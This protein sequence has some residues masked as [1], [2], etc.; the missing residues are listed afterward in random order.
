RDGTWSGTS[1]SPPRPPVSIW[2]GASAASDRWSDPANWEGNAAPLAGDD[3]VFPGMAV[4]FAGTNDLPGDTMFRSI[5]FSGGDYVLDGNRVVL[6]EGGYTASSH[7]N[8]AI[9]YIVVRYPTTYAVVAPALVAEGNTL[10][11]AGVVSGSAEIQKVGPGTL[12]LS[13]PN[14]YTGVTL[15]E[16]G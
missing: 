16:E 13:G 3:L 5:T 14:T 15:V 9:N 11:L 6:G 1:T 7:E 4:R 2:T 10:E 8:R 12:I